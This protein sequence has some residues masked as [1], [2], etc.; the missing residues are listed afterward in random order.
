MQVIN[1]NVASLNAQRNLGQSQNALSTSLQR[2]SS[3]LRINSAKDDAAGLAISERMGGQI[4]GLDQATRNANDA[5]SL[6]QTAEGGLGTAGDI[7]QRVRELAVQSANG[8][9]TSSDR[10]AL[11][12]E[13]SQMQQEINRVA[14]TTQFNGQNIL[15]GT[16]SN[17]SFQIGANSN[18]TISFGIGSVSGTAIGN[19]ALKTAVGA[20]TSTAATTAAG[21]AAANNVAGQTLTVAGNGTSAAVTVSAGDTANAIAAAVNAN[22]ATT[23]VAAEAK[24]QATLSSLAQAGTLTFNLYGKNGTAVAIAATV[25]ST[26]NLD[27]L[28]SVINNNTATTG[29]TATS[30]NGTVTLTSNDG[31][32]IKI[33]NFLNSAGT[34]GTIAFQGADPFAATATTSG[35]AVTLGGATGTDSSTVGGRVQFNSSNAY[36]VTTGTAGTIFAAATPQAGALASVSSIDI[37]T[38]SGAQD[39]IKIVDAALNSVNNLRA[40]MGALQNRFGSTI[41]NLQTTSENL[42]AA[43]SRVRD[44]DFAKETASLTRGQILQQAGVAML[45]Q[46]NQLPQQVLQ[47]LR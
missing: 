23:G 32:D 43:R 33:E 18:Q 27:S 28:A 39:A 29:I 26:T 14:S 17:A 35:A 41:T 9:N 1:T 20:G 37:S 16:L 38:S 31:Y 47:L 8:T 7:L 15:D 30:S 19:Y 45:S 11:Q 22:S 2:L 12:L 10:Q 44:A 13:V 34:G 4:R 24:T 25:G 42:S 5:I 3:G 21:A 6:S 46:A 36:T 40:Q